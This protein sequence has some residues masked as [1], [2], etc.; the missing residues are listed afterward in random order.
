M[1]AKPK[2]ATERQKWAID[3][4][5]NSKLEYRNSKQLQNSNNEKAFSFSAFFEF[6]SSNLFRISSVGVRILTVIFRHSHRVIY[7]ECTIGNH[8]Y[9]SRYLDILETARGEFFRQLGATFL[10]WQQNDFI[11]PVV[12]CRL[13][14]KAPARYDDLLTIETW[15]TSIERIRLNFACRILKEQGLILEAETLHVCTGLDEKPKRLPDELCS[16]L[17]PYLHEST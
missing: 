4:Y 6:R 16:L 7:S 13:R 1:S 8:V 5:K 14:Y 9:Y 11:F 10:Q 15:L 2:L 17:K 12:E 3:V